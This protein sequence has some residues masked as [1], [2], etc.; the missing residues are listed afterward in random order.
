MLRG[1]QLALRSQILLGQT[2]TSETGDEQELGVCGPSCPLMLDTVQRWPLAGPP[3]VSFCESLFRL[4][5]YILVIIIT[6][7]CVDSLACA[8]HVTFFFLSETLKQPHDGK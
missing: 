6:C 4:S 3:A 2:L 1:H 8:K 5:A 7:Y